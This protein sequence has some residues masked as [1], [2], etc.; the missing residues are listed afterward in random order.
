G[1][2]LVLAGGR[3]HG[4]AFCEVL[5]V[6]DLFFVIVVVIIVVIVIVAT[7][8]TATTGVVIIGIIF[9]VG[10]AIITARGF[11]AR[12]GSKPQVEQIDVSTHGRTEF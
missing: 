2:R 11:L 1:P 10:G 4:A 5:V 8:A 6:Y 12:S 9:T 7:T 3:N